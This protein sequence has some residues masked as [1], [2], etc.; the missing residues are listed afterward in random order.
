[1]VGFSEEMRAWGKKPSSMMLSFARTEPNEPAREFLGSGPVYRIERLRL[2]DGTPMAVEEVH[3][4]VELCPDLENYDL[5]TRSLY[6][7][8]DEAYQLRFVRCEQIVSASLPTRSQRRLLDIGLRVALLN[9]I[10]RSFAKSD[11]PASY[12]ITQY[13]GDLYTA[14]VHGQWLYGKRYLAGGHAE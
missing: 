2:A 6:E 1:M 7:I 11:R 4:P 9:V 10:R 14:S 12:G 8:L 5:T 13:R 3:I